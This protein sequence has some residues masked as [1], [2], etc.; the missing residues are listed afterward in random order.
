MAK[1]VLTARAVAKA[2][3]G[4]RGGRGGDGGGGR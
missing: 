1:V 3:G 4:H 2:T